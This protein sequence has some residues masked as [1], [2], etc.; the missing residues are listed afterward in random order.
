MQ[1]NSEHPCGWHFLQGPAGGTSIITFMPDSLI[2][3]VA[4]ATKFTTSPC[5]MFATVGMFRPTL[6]AFSSVLA[7]SDTSASTPSPEILMSNRAPNRPNSSIPALP[8]VEPCS[9]D[10]NDE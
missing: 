1:R 6:G 2:R 5:V 10:A 3:V 9:K 7:M 8:L 4:L